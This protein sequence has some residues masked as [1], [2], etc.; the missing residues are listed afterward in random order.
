MLHSEG[1]RLFENLLT[2]TMGTTLFEFYLLKN[3]TD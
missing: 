1:G 2:L 3:P